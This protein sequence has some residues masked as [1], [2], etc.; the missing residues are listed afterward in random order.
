[1][2]L[3][4][5]G[6]YKNGKILLRQPKITMLIMGKFLLDKIV[7][8]IRVIESEGSQI[9]QTDCDT[10]FNCHRSLYK[11]YSKIALLKD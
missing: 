1:M 3:E 7:H 8:L 11:S 5:V 4:A 6:I 9:K 2:I 10:Y